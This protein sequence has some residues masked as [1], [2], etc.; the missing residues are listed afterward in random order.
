MPQ[1][2]LDGPMGQ[3]LLGSHRLYSGPEE[4]LEAER[5]AARELLALDAYLPKRSPG[6]L[7]PKS[8]AWRQMQSLAEPL[9]SHERRDADVIAA[10]AEACLVKLRGADEQSMDLLCRAM[11]LAQA[12]QRLHG[13][14][15][16]RLD[17]PNAEDAASAYRTLVKRLR[18]AQKGA[19]A[20]RVVTRKQAEGAVRWKLQPGVSWSKACDQAA[21]RLGITGRWVRALLKDSPIRPPRRR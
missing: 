20:R 3:V 5:D 11:E 19:E 15:I 7:H 6:R 14:L 13:S 16:S 12:L 10:A 21:P 18:G 17:A 1:S 2:A 9:A 4:W 8:T